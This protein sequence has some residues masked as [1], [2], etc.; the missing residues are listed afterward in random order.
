MIDVKW[1]KSYPN[2]SI[3][4]LLPDDMRRPDKSAAVQNSAAAASPG[5]ERK[6]NNNELVHRSARV[7]R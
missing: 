4:V 6:M 2:L 5:Q 3:D 7:K 1:A